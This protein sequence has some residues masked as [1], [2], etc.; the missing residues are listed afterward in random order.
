M[1]EFSG[2]IDENQEALPKKGT[3]FGIEP[4]HF[5]KQS[6]LVYDRRIAKISDSAVIL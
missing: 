3:E 4:V 1:E 2:Q 5:D 6:R